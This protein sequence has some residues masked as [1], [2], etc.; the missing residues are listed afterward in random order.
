M[1]L[2][3]WEWWA[4]RLC[5]LCPAHYHW[6]GRVRTSLPDAPSKG[7]GP[8]VLLAKE[9]DGRGSVTSAGGEGG[10]TWRAPHVHPPAGGSVTR[11]AGRRGRLPLNC[12]AP[13]LPLGNGWRWSRSFRHIP[14]QSRSNDGSIRGPWSASAS[15]ASPF[16]ASP[17]CTGAQRTRVRRRQSDLA[18]KFHPR[19]PFLFLLLLSA[20]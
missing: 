9:R 5:V 19:S 20:I 2:S 12:G 15:R 6:L 10:G 17:P 18:L 16:Q 13:A 8:P 14:W 1:F 11:S 4:L 3:P 7:T